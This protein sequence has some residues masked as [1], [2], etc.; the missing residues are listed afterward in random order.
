[1]AEG[2]NNTIG[3]ANVELGADTSKLSA[4]LKDAK[5][6]TEE[7]VAA[8]EKKAAEA[9]PIKQ[10]EALGKSMGNLITPVASVVSVFSRLLGMFSLITAAFGGLIAGFLAIKNA[11][12]AKKN[13]AHQA[14]LSIAE[15]GKQ[16]DALQSKK[17]TETFDPDAEA[18]A[19]RKVYDER[20]NAELDLYNK[21]ISLADSANQRTTAER[22]ITESRARRKEIEDELAMRL[23]ALYRYQDAMR[24]KR[25]SDD[26][27]IAS[28][29]EKAEKEL[30]EKINQDRRDS[31]SQLIQEYRE[32]SEFYANQNAEM[33]R[34]QQQQFS[35]LRNEINGLF[36]TNQLEIGI[37]RLG[38]LM[39]I[40]V[41]KIGDSR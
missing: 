8:V 25:I 22:L 40:M 4:G 28:E 38:A 11:L 15:L 5:K 34:A 29:I 39:E 17:I 31:M 20:V 3:R 30:Q 32:V 36:N 7:T 18:N 24:N 16:L 14:A 9:A 6:Q 2:G 19:I 13:A 12:E 21:Q 27:M 33:M 41:Q 1:M 35:Q 37:N 26:A 23:D 10:T